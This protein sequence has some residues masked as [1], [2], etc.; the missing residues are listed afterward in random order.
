MNGYKKGAF[1][2][3]GKERHRVALS[4]KKRKKANRETAKKAR[5]Q[6]S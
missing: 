5:K 3:R 2:G 4:S 1:R 6:K